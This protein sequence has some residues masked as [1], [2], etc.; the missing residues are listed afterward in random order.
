M[1]RETRLILTETDFR[2]LTEFLM[3]DLHMPVYNRK[4]LQWKLKTA[5]IVDKEWLPLNV[6]TT[7]SNVLVLNTTKNQTF[8]VHI[9][10]PE[11]YDG[12]SHQILVSDPLAVALLGYSRGEDVECEL[13]SGINRLKVLSVC[14]LS[15]GEVLV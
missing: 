8:T 14:Q 1:V 4:K 13:P 5:R 3:E 11:D 15:T 12:S 10:S 9:V 6:V 7:N 2:L